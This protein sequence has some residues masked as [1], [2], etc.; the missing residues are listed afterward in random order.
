MYRLEILHCSKYTYSIPTNRLSSRYIY[1]YSKNRGIVKDL[2]L[3]DMNT[4][5]IYLCWCSVLGGFI[6]PADS[7]STGLG[8][9]LFI[10]LKAERGIP[11]RL[12]GAVAQWLE[13]APAAQHCKN[14]LSWLCQLQAS[15]LASFS[16]RLF[17]R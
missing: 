2:T 16:R 9:G 14:N 12:W 1:S 13:H 4:S 7:S 10:T 3:R 5:C 17:S 15:I 6:T 11:N 8:I